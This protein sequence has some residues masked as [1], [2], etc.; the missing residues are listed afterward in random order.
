MD[1]EILHFAIWELRIMSLKLAGQIS[2]F[3]KNNNFLIF[4]RGGCFDFEMPGTF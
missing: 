2:K 3:L 1:T 4:L